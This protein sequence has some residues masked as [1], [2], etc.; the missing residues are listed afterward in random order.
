[1]L[2]HSAQRC[3]RNGFSSKATRPI[4]QDS[5]TTANPLQVSPVGAPSGQVPPSASALLPSDQGW[6]QK[7]R[8]RW[9][10]VKSVIPQYIPSSNQFEI[11][12]TSS[13]VVCSGETSGGIVE[14]ALVAPVDD[15]VQPVVASV[16]SVEDVASSVVEVGSSLMVV[17][18]SVQDSVGIPPVVVTGVDL[19]GVLPLCFPAFHEDSG[20]EK[21][22]RL[23]DSSALHVSQSLPLPARL[24]AQKRRSFKKQQA[25][26]RVPYDRPP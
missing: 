14:G 11:L 20:P 9:P 4:S 3:S 18:P 12:Q 16:V 6:I 22:V 19:L 15:M 5:P 21:K 24:L 26:S 13:D 23:L 7:R 1:M 25:K 8:R 2:G 10:F 17:D